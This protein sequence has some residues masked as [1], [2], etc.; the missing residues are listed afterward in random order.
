MIDTE[1][2]YIIQNWIK[3]SWSWL[4]DLCVKD[5]GLVVAITFG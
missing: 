1:F 3:I 4:L 2:W 5:G